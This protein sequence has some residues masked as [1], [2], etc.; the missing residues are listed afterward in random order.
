M[1]KAY[2]FVFGATSTVLLSAFLF[3]LAPRIQVS[4]VE[5]AGISAQ[6]PYTEVEQR[7]R[8][9]YIEYGCLNCHSQQVR[10]PSAG[11]DYAFGWGRPSRPSDY[12]H[13]RPHLL[14][15]S[16][17]GPDLS[18]I[19]VRQ[20]SRD[21]HHLHMYDPRLL[22][23]WSIMPAHPFLYS[24]V[25]AEESPAPEALAIPER[26]NAWLVPSEDAEALVAY[27]MSLQ[28]EADAE[29]EAAA[30]EQEVTP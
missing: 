16:R 30:A 25:E 23:P 17:T 7:G 2:L 21:W 28:R 24:V 29:A 26:E 5:K 15:T 6:R 9:V 22:V 1:D 11:A 18:N 13:D 20:P 3:V 14:G 10:D 4:E 19:G 27:L 8:Q 12:I